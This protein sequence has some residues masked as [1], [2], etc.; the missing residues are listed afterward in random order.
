MRHVGL[1]GQRE[2]GLERRRRLGAPPQGESRVA[3]GGRQ[4]G[5]ERERRPLEAFLG[6]LPKP[7]EIVG[8]AAG[9]DADKAFEIGRRIA[10]DGAAG[11]FREAQRLADVGLGLVDFADQGPRRGERTDDTRPSG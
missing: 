1:F 6:H 4:P 8:A 5:V 7:I 11:R 9:D 3:E 10:V 2:G